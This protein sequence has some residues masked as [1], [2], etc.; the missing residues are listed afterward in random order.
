MRP[1][2]STR[3]VRLAS[4][5][6][7]LSLSMMPGACTP[8]EPQPGSPGS[9]AGVAEA[10]D[11]DPVSTVAVVTDATGATPS[12]SGTKRPLATPPSEV[13]VPER[14][15]IPVTI[16]LPFQPDVQFAPIY[17]ALANGAFLSAEGV[18]LDPTIEYGDENDFLRLLAAGKMDAVV[19]SG[20]QV[21][22]ARAGGIP[23]TYVATWYQ[24]FPV[25]VFGLDPAI[26]RAEDLAGLKV[27]L[28]MQAGASWIGW[29]ALLAKSGI[30]LEAI[31]TEVVGFEQL[32]S[33]RAGRVDAAV[34]YAANEPVRLLADGREPWVIEIADSFNLVSNGLVVAESAIVERPEV[35]QA[36]VDAFLAGLADTLA[37]PDRAFEV[38]LESV[39]AADDDAVRPIQRRVLE[40]SLPYWAPPEGSPLGSIDKARWTD[41]LAFLRQIGLID[42]SVAAADLYDDRFVRRSGP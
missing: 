3:T 9:A 6:V 19:A 38:A 16:G 5:T 12:D 42:Q 34:G 18:P 13:Q 11:A 7:L 15:P 33:V 2:G 21:I 24:R 40:A 30:P 10:T 17:T 25:V 27:G 31:D 14:E 41:S 23:V 28:P 36:L 20:E 26:T 29:Q 37:D 39:P 35:V 4:L 32:T 22:L 1:M 8:P